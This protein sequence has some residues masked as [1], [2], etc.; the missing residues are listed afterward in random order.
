MTSF[1]FD[2]HMNRAV[3]DA[4]IER[5]YQV[6][7]AVDVGMESKDDDAEHLPYA[8]EHGLVMVTFDHPFAS[9]TMSSDMAHPG[10]I[11]LA[12]SIRENIGRMIEVLV[13]FAELYDPEQDAGQ[14]FWLS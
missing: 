11:C 10:L 3:A 14:V 12:Y 8:A 4:L 6:V 5:G 9:R 7:M 1:Y 2:E 13:E